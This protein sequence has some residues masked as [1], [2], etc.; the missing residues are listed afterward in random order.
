MCFASNSV[1]CTVRSKLNRPVTTTR[2]HA[3]FIILCLS[4]FL[5]LLLRLRYI[6]KHAAPNEDEA[7]TT[8]SKYASAIITRAVETPYPSTLH[9]ISAHLN[10]RRLRQQCWQRKGQMLC[11]CAL[12]CLMAAFLIFRFTGTHVFMHKKCNLNHMNRLIRLSCKV[13]LRDILSVGW[14]RSVIHKDLVLWV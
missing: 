13:S 14:F 3:C 2:T 6:C 8:T 1:E 7:S 5:E 9:S 4:H 12:M 10:L 11:S